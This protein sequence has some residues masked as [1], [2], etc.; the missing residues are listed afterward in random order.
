MAMWLTCDDQTL[1]LITYH[2]HVALLRPLSHQQRCADCVQT[3]TTNTSANDLSSSSLVVEKRI[4][5]SW[6]TF[7]HFGRQPTI[8]V[9][10]ATRATG[11]K[12]TV[13]SGISRA[14]R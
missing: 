11:N 4:R 9:S 7:P 10:F 12:W 14:S 13:R 1:L 5:P 2:T 6:H 3:E 8:L